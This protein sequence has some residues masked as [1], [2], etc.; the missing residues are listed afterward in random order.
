VTTDQKVTAVRCY[1]SEKIP[2]S[3]IADELKVHPNTY[4]EWQRKFFIN[5]EAP[6]LQ[7]KLPTKAELRKIESLEQKV[8]RKDMMIFE[9]MSDY[10]QPKKVWWRLQNWRTISDSPI[11]VVS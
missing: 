3:T 6:F 4:Y 1:L 10:V 7:E 11:L 8:A 9:I 5:G 2:V